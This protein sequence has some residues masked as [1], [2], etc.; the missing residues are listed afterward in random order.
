MAAEKAGKRPDRRP[1]A[2][3]DSKVLRDI[4]KDVPVKEFAARCGVKQGEMYRFLSENDRDS[5]N[6]VVL[7][8]TLWDIS[9]NLKININ[10]LIYYGDCRLPD[11]AEAYTRFSFGWFTDNPREGVRPGSEDGNSIWLSEIIKWQHPDENAQLQG[12][13]AL[14][15][16]TENRLKYKF[17]LQAELLSPHLFVVRSVGPV[18]AKERSEGPIQGKDRSVGPVHDKD[19]TRCWVGVMD[20]LIRYQ[21]S[22]DRPPVSVLCGLWSGIHVLGGLGV[23]RWLLSDGPL[24]PQDLQEISTKVLIRIHLEGKA[25]DL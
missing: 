10:Q 3:I 20:R 5:E 4:K 7:L 25:F 24:G 17:K 15:A 9:E 12:R 14:E 16:K 1:K 6:P 11:T 22:K 18:R 23:Y 13:I 19:S 2:P 21:V 8:S